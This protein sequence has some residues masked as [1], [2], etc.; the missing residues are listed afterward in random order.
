M[1]GTHQGPLY[2]HSRRFSEG[3]D[4]KY[5]DLVQ[6]HDSITN[7]FTKGKKYIDLMLS[8]LF[9]EW[10]HC[11]TICIEK[12]RYVSKSL[13]KLSCYEFAVEFSEDWSDE[14]QYNDSIASEAFQTSMLTETLFL[15]Y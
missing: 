3:P 2:W 13:N 5:Y 10:H 9:F 8:T 1:K 4:R 7:M 12:Y 11:N 14:K 6:C 15:I